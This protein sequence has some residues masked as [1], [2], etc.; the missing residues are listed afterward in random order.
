MLMANPF[1]FLIHGVA[2]GQNRIMPEKV[3]SLML[4]TTITST[5]EISLLDI[6]LEPNRQAQGE[7][8]HMLSPMIYPGCRTR[9]P[10]LDMVMTKRLR[11]LGC[12]SGSFLA[13]SL[14]PRI[15]GIIMG[16]DVEMS[17]MLL[18]SHFGGIEYT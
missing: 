7:L 10:S 5:L 4:S 13:Y 1:L 17:D 2:F 15:P 8:Q 16:S 3:P 9:G 14:Q 6:C 11:Y 18:S 12:M